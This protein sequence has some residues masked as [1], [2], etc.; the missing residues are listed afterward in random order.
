MAIERFAQIGFE[1]EKNI[2]VSIADPKDPFASHG[3]GGFDGVFDQNPNFIVQANAGEVGLQEE[4]PLT[5][6][7]RENPEKQ[8]FTIL[9]FIECDMGS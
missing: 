8:I 1:N 5:R 9:T 3:V 2:Q 6:L 7:L 4:S